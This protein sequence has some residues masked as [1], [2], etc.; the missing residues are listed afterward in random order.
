[1]NSIPR[2]NLVCA[3]FNYVQY[4]RLETNQEEHLKAAI[5]E[6]T[7]AIRRRRHWIN[8]I[9][10]AIDF[11]AENG[12]IIY[13]VLLFFH[14]TMVLQYVCGSLMWFMFSILVPL[15]HLMNEDR[16]KTII[17]Q[18]GWR[19]GIKSVFTVASPSS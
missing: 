6:K 4:F 11:L 16:V 8:K 17:I 2:F 19:E 5:S 1:M 3:L 7:K 9:L 13:I 15:A 12:S 10:H 18:S 14:Q